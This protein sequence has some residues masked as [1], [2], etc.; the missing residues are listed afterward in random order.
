MSSK[1]I[2]ERAAD[3]EDGLEISAEEAAFLEDAI[4]QADA[5]PEAGLSWEE[6]REQLHE[7]P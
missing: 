4:V 6:F 3:G 2:N 7:R 1:S 5:D